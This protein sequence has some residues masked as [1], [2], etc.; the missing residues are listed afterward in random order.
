MA[1]IEIY[2]KDWCPYC[3]KAKA[4]LKS[5]H[6][7]YTEIDVTSNTEREHQ[8][9]E[10]SGRRTVPQIFVAGRSIGGYDDLAQLNAT[11]ELDRLLGIEP[12]HELV[13]VYDVVVIGAGP[14]GMSAA[15]YAA[16]KNLSTA[17]VTFDL[18]GQMG[19]THEIANYPGFQLVTGPDLVQRFSEHAEQYGIDR[20]VGERVTDI[21][22][23]NRCK[24]I[25]TSSGQVINAK[26]VIVATG[27]FKR[28][29]NIPGEKELTGK[30]VVYCSTCDGPL[31]KGMTVAVVGGG[32]SALEA[33]IEMNGIARKVF[34]VSIGEWTGDQILQDH[35]ATAK[36][37]EVLKH[38]EPVQIHGTKHVEGLTIK[39]LNSGVQRRLDVQGVF[40]EIGLFPNSD[41][42]LDLLETN[43]CGEIKIDRQGDTG[44]RGVFAAGDVTDTPEK[45]IVIAAGEGA[46]AALA[47]FEYLVTQV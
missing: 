11:G 18:G 1:K 22:L 14:A 32:N 8:M 15:I 13:K 3:N 31:F 2:S 38:H 41:F 28:R 27:A 34:L 5:K 6:L 37:V 7:S 9:I 10:R 4:L 47:A 24:I 29:L 43:E 44:V 30:G 25:Y 35:V 36:Q 12:A 45:Q 20:I 21:T 39:D 46:L 19:T 26:S 40:I 17:V 16:R 42:A 23:E 33:A